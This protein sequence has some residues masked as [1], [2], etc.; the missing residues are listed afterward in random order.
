MGSV[1]GDLVHYIPDI[2]GEALSFMQRLHQRL[3]R[4]PNRFF[5][6]SHPLYY[7]TS[8]SLLWLY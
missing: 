5:S 4:D 6:T 7:N 3:C 1:D 8:P 2:P